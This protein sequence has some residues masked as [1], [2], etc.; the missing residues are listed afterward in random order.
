MANETRIVQEKQ[1][2][3]NSALLIWIIFVFVFC[4]A[5]F[6]AILFLIV[7]IFIFI[8]ILLKLFLLNNGIFD[9]FFS[10]VFIINL[11]TQ[12]NVMFAMIIYLKIGSKNEYIC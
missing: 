12:Y 4:F 5:E 6:C 2:R 9:V 1:H 3:N 11:K 7:F 10:L 8:F